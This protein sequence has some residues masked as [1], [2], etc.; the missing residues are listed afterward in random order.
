MP[1]INTDEWRNEL[2]AVMA[3]VTT[4]DIRMPV[5]KDRGFTVYD[6]M[7]HHEIKRW[8]AIVIIKAGLQKKTIRPIGYRPG[9]GGSRVYETIKGE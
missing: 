6:I 4:R 8:K 3:N 9:T 7:E 1:K 2:D 5:I